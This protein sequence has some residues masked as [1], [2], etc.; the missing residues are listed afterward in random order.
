MYASSTSKNISAPTG[1]ELGCPIPFPLKSAY[2]I[3][4]APT[5]KF[6]IFASYLPNQSS[7]IFSL[8]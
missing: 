5:A 8:V 4:S 3:L 7:L 1:Q 2:T 6:D